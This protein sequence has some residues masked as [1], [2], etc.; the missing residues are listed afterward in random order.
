MRMAEA[1]DP[2]VAVS[3]LAKRY[4]DRTVVSGV[5][6][7]AA[8]GDVVGLVGANGGGKTTTLR[9]LAGLV[10]PDAG[11]GTVLNGP[12]GRA[13]RGR[14]ALIGYMG[15]RQSLYPE[16]KPPE[17]LGFCAAVHGLGR[18]A[19][20][21]AIARF[22]LEPV[23]AQRCATLSGGW[24]RRVQFA[25]TVIA[26][27]SLLLLDEPTAGLDVKTRGDLWRWVGEEAARGAA[28]VISTHDL[29][30]AE[31]CSSILFYHAG[32]AHPQTNPAAL[33]AELGLPSLEAAVL[34]IAQGASV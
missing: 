1:P 2:C 32:V 31:R 4:G 17:M 33:S 12:V 27:P 24:A 22:G 7:T 23:L 10:R 20:D 8:G 19:V 25:A 9:M 16:L 21:A 30:E 5:G 15:Q 13:E 11:T 34:H 6:M 18:D 26:R 14:R 29:I 28:V 3:G